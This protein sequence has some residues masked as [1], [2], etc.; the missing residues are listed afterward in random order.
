M[1]QIKPI[2]FI[3]ESQFAEFSNGHVGYIY[4]TEDELVDF[5]KLKN[6]SPPYRFAIHSPFI[7]NDYHYGYSF[8]ESLIS[9]Y[10][11]DYNIVRL[12]NSDCFDSDSIVWERS[13]DDVAK[14]FKDNLTE[15]DIL[16][17]KYA[18]LE[19]EFRKEKE[20]SEKRFFRIRSLVKANVKIKELRKHCEDLQCENTNL[21]DKYNY[22]NYE[23][24]KLRKKLNSISKNVTI[25][26]YNAL[27]KRYNNLIRILLKIRVATDLD[28]DDVKEVSM[29]D[30]YPKVAGK[31]NLDDC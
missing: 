19:V 22:A 4:Q 14:D 16:R 3:A 13:Y 15:L 30:T 25:D 27:A 18:K 24:N 2:Y 10:H 21:I 28:I 29:L 12:Y 8:T 31:I 9:S 6:T 7:S 11:S 20:L 26:D 5:P 1:A 23:F 17:Q